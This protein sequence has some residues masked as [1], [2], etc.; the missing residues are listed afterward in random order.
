[1]AHLAN[2]AARVGCRGPEKLLASVGRRSLL[3][4]RMWLLIAMPTDV[5]YDHLASRA[6]QKTCQ[7]LAMPIHVLPWLPYTAPQ[8][9][10]AQQ[11][12]SRMRIDPDVQN[13]QAGNA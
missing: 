5:P 11:S 9:T 10:T 12:P 2:W 1:M 13:Q 4:V 7:S 3:T 6:L 8:Y